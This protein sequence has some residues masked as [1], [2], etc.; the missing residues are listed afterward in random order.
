MVNEKYNNEEYQQ[1]GIKGEKNFEITAKECGWS[2]IEAT[3]NQDYLL[4]IDFIIEGFNKRFTVEVK[5]MKKI[6][7][8]DD[9]YQD[10]WIWLELRGSNYTPGWIYGGHAD[11]IAFEQSDCFI[12]VDRK[13]LIKL[14]SEKVDPMKRVDR[15]FKAHYKAYSRKDIGDLVTLVHRDDILDIMELRFEKPKSIIKKSEFNWK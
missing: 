11:L 5:A 7:R 6:S 15:P 14:I 8:S 9:D 13:K 1:Q 4:H 2:I 12:L 10:E 3:K